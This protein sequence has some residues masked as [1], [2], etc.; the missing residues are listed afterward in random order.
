MYKK[1]LKYTHVTAEQMADRNTWTNRIK[2]THAKCQMSINVQIGQGTNVIIRRRKKKKDI[3][4]PRQTIVNKTLHRKLNIE[5][6]E[7][8]LKTGVEFRY[9]GMK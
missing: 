7:T 5:P 4:G 8:P 9:S 2:L 3:Q 1:G 6:H